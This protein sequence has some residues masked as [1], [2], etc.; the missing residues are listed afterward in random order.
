MGWSAIEEEVYSAVRDLY[1]F[2]NSTT[3]VLVIIQYNTINQRQVE[4][5]MEITFQWNSAFHSGTINLKWQVKQEKSY[6]M[7]E[8][9][10]LPYAVVSR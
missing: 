8:P 3:S 7:D 9:N 4:L 2:K 1:C 10:N 6:Y 5:G